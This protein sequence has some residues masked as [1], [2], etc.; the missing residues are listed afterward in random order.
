MADHDF[1]CGDI[2]RCISPYYAEQLRITT[3]HGIVMATKPHHIHVW[4]EAQKRGFWITY[5]ILRRI[6]E[7]ELTPLLE[8]IRTLAYLL[9]AEEWE[10]EETAEVYRLI[11]YVDEE[12]LETLM[13]LRASLDIHYRALS[14]KPEGMGRMIAQI[15]W[16]KP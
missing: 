5:D 15:E 11:C 2:V 9:N 10:L 1:R 7:P 16:L 8:R 13:E 3:Q 6:P 4:F 14:L 12:P